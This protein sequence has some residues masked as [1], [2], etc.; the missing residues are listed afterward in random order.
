MNYFKSKRN[1]WGLPLQSQVKTSLP[2]CKGWF[3][4]PWSGSKDPTCLGAKKK[5]RT[6]NIKQKQYYNKFNKN[7]KKWSTL[8][9][10]LKKKKESLILDAEGNKEHGGIGAWTEGS[11][12]VRCPMHVPSSKKAWE[13]GHVCNIFFG[14]SPRS[15]YGPANALQKRWN[16]LPVGH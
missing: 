12:R 16:V 10:I 7:L 2:Q 8:K 15:Q 11:C 5:K 9:N 13:R 3:S 4:N 6:Q 14:S 1:P